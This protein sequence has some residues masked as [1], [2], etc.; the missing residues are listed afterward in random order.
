MLY[1][2]FIILLAVSLLMSLNEYYLFKLALGLSGALACFVL[3]QST[4]SKL[5]PTP[6]LEWLARLGRATL[7]VYV[8]QAILLEY[9]L[10]RYMNLTSLPYAMIILLMP[11]MA[12]ITLL[13]T[14]TIAQLISR[15]ELMGWLL[16][17]HA[18]KR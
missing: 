15:L 5:Q 17:G 8:L 16:L 18:Y 12:L 1:I 2:I 9:L 6:T 10:P 14:Y 3:F 7:G 13:V 11:F 4:I